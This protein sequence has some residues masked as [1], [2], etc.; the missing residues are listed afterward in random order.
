MRQIHF[1][2][3]T[4]LAV[5]PLFLNAANIVFFINAIGKS[6]L[7]FGDSLIDSL[8]EKG[9]TVDLVI[10]RI[11]DLAKGNENSKADR[12]YTLGFKNGSSWHKLNHLTSPFEN[13]PFPIDGF[14]QYTLIGNQ[15]CEIA[16]H[17]EKLHQFLSEKSYDVGVV[18]VFDYCGI[19]IL[20]K[21][22]VSSITTFN[23]VPL[24][25]IQTVTIGL[26][27][28]ASQ[29]VPLFYTFDLATLSG[30]LWNLITW[31]H[32]NFHQIP[33]LRKEQELLFQKVYGPSFSINEVIDKVDLSFVNSN[34]IMETPMLIN[35]R[36][37]Y[38]GGINLKTPK[39]VDHHLD[40]LLSKSSNGTI[41][42]SF[43]TQIPGAVYPRYAVRNFVKVFKKYPE[44]T[45]LWKYNV[46][47]GEEK[48]FEDAENV[49]LLDWLPQTDL[50]YDPRVI[51]FISH[52]GLN[53]FNE[54]SYA[55]KPIIAI[56]LF[57]DQPHNARNG[58]ARGTTYLLNKSKLSE[59]S[60]ENGLRA[61][62]FD[63]SYTE[64]ARKLQKMLVEKPTKP[65]D[66]F[67][68]WMEYAAVNPGLHKI[69]A[70]PGAK[71]GNI[72]YYCVDTIVFIAFSCV[73]FTYIFFKMAKFSLSFIRLV[74]KPKHE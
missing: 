55:G 52:V 11:N 39:P 15:L 29:V 72:E 74:K 5:L 19:G 31:A 73:T 62:L 25:S 70:L 18:S 59:E 10:A 65:K 49:I 71:M 22:G 14:R 40:N 4:I 57:A 36:I 8:K 60:I 6:H 61:I 3:L 35:H 46:Q 50:L 33:T 37:Q 30:K 7:D 56:P 2:A 48:L 54:A 28:I 24:M 42:F 68:E 34:E 53:S 17:D 38:I 26:P 21:A 32:I 43:G 67:V 16:L 13:N 9:H 1:C 41:I 12:F 44:Y 20:N 69:F 66:R 58:V 51:G 23:A 64:S 63:K 45:F 47:P 27:N